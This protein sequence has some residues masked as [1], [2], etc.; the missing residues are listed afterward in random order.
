MYVNQIIAEN[1]V[2]FNAF[3]KI[4]RSKRDLSSNLTNIK[5]LRGTVLPF[6]CIVEKYYN[7]IVVY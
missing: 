6:L 5:M 2:K 3:G 1:A 7:Y 4:I